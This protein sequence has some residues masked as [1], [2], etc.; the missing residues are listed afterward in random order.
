[1]KLKI[2]NDVLRILQ[3]LNDDGHQCLVIG[4]AVRDAIMGIEPKDIDIEVYKI[5]G[6]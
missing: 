6:F 3:E 5:T 1:M 2:N 4:G